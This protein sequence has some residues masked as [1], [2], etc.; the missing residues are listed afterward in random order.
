MA[1]ALA[2]IL[3]AVRAAGRALAARPPPPSTHREE[4][5]DRAPSTASPRRR[6]SSSA[7]CGGPTATCTPSTGSTC[8]SRPARWSCCSG[9]RA[10][11]RP[12]PCGSSPASSATTTGAVL[13]GRQGPHPGAAQQARHG[14]GVPGLQPVPA[15]D[16]ARQRRVRAQAARPRRAPSGASGPATCSTW[17]GSASTHDRYAHQLSGGQQQRV[18]LARALAIEPAVLLLDEPLS[19]LDA[20]VRVQLRDEIRRVQLEVGTTTLFVTHDQEEALAI[21]DRVGVMNAGRL[22]QIAPPVGALR[23]ARD[24]VRRPVRRPQQPDPDSGRTTASADV[25]RLAAPGAAGISRRVRGRTGADRS[26][27]QRRERTTRPRPPSPRWRSSARSRG[28]RSRWPT[29]PS[30]SPSCPAREAVAAVGRRAG[31]GRGRPDPGARRR[32]LTVDSRGIGCAHGGRARAPG[33]GLT[34]RSCASRT[35]SA[36]RSPRSCARPRAT[37]GS[38]STS[39]TSGSRRP[40]PPARTPTWCRSPSTCPA[41]PHQ[42]VPARSQASPAGGPRPGQREP[43]RDPRRAEPQGRLDRSRSR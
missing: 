7:A 8:G 15:P 23:R 39:S 18:A 26:A 35:P 32:G 42:A 11:A 13:V 17:S 2:S 3:L 27:V 40:T 10:A 14:H 21:A 33:G 30:W 12:R 22:D 38:T 4:P 29:A 31:A 19:A 34:R 36:T 9:R 43:H 24:A 28:P 41:H 20:K 16:R 37:A 5:H 1:A 25:L 6:P